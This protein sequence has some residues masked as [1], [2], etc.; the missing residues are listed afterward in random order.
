MGCAEPARVDRDLG[1]RR[2]TLPYQLEELGD[3]AVEEKT[4]AAASVSR[5]SS[6]SSRRLSRLS[7]VRYS[8]LHGG[9]AE[10]RARLDVK[11]KE[12]AV[13]VAEALAAEVFAEDVVDLF[14]SV[15]RGGNRWPRCR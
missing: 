4:V 13:K 10:L 2:K 15:L 12:Q 9:V 3:G 11:E 8:S 7:P 5:G 6:A 1:E 14:P